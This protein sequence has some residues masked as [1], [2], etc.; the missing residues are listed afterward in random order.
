MKNKKSLEK[1]T[2]K[3]GKNMK[4]VNLTLKHLN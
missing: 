1:K 3:S 2:V 4:T